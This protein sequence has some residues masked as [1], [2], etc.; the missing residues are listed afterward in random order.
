MVV[1]NYDLNE[2]LR[3]FLCAEYYEF[4]TDIFYETLIN[5][6]NVSVNNIDEF[7]DKEYEEYSDEE[8]LLYKEVLIELIKKYK[9]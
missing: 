8:K 7:V 4:G 1:V 9:K 2:I 5:P 6:I 3:L